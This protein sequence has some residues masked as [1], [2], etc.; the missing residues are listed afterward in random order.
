MCDCN[1]VGKHGRPG[2]MNRRDFIKSVISVGS[3]TIMAG[4]LGGH[5]QAQDAP[6]AKVAERLM[7]LNVNGRQR[8]VGVMPP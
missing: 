6:T 1:D 3:V 7:T 4:S 8:R 2:G 5:V